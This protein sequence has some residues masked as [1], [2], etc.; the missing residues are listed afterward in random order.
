MAIV[1]R[2]VTDRCNGCGNC[3]MACA[4][5]HARGTR[6]AQPRIHVLGRQTSPG[7]GTPI[8]CLQCDEP[9]CVEV[10]PIQALSRDE[11]TGAIRLDEARCIRCRSCVAACPFGNVAWDAA[12]RAVV[13]CDLC[14]GDPQCARF[15]PTGALS[16]RTGVSPVRDTAASPVRDAGVSPVR[17]PGVPAC[18]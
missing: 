17:D 14:G 16:S 7:C 6:P 9:A 11:A 18:S 5:V 3:E 15:C 8:L 4:F 1:L 10:C 12:Q 13:K 2:V